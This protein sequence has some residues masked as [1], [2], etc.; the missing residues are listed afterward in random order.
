MKTN[1]TLAK[2]ETSLTRLYAFF[3]DCHPSMILKA[4]AHLSRHRWQIWEK[5]NEAANLVLNK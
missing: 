2:C 4:L 1:I 3:A 5:I